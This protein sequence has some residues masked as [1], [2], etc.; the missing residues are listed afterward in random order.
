MVG[1]AGSGTLH[2][3]S[4]FN[5]N[6]SY[7]WCITWRKNKMTN[8]AKLYH[9]PDRAHFGVGVKF[10]LLSGSLCLTA[11]RIVMFDYEW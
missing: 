8:A 9:N 5:C 10:A 11:L 2:I 1:S 7:P 4:G 6:T 3:V